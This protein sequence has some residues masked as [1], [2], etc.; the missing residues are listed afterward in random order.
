MLVGS[1]IG[2]AVGHRL[3]LRIRDTVTDALGLVTLL[4][5]GLSASDVTDP[6]L[7]DAVGDEAPVLI[8]LG[9][10]VVG[11]IIGS[12]VGV[13]RRLETVGGWLRDRLAGAGAT[14]ERQRFIEGFLTASLV[15]CVGPLTILGSLEDGFGNGS[16]Q[17][18]LKSIL[19]GFASIAFAASFGI[20]VM[21]SALSVLIIQG[22][23]TAL[24]AALGSFVPEA[25]LLALTATGGILLA[26]VSLRLLQVKAV[27]VGDLLP[28]LV[29]AP[30]LT[31]LVTIVR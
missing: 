31:E 19:D 25:H 11:G 3:P 30:L 7:R 5:A 17:L 8:V 18:I 10:V 28:A 20:G 15:F 1:G 9:A 24:A 27:P 22:S 13:E 23:L 6:V 14:G 26:G 12:L 2:I 29:V 4:S 16:E 21:A